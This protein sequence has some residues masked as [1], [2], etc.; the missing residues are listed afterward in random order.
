MSR[1]SLL[2]AILIGLA[3]VTVFPS[4]TAAPLAK[5]E[6]ALILMHGKWGRTPG[7]LARYF[8]REGYRVF[9]PEMPWSGRRLY[10]VNYRV[11]LE[12]V[13]REVERL[14]AA[15]AKKV[16]VGGESFGANGALAYQAVYGDADALLILAP[17]HMPGSWY[18]SGQ[19]RDDV[20][21]ASALSKE[22]KG[23]ER[24][25]FTDFNQE[26]QRNLSPTVD[27]FL[28][29]FRPNGLANMSASAKR[30][31]Q[32]VPVLVVNST[33]EVKNQGKGYIFDALPPHPRSVYIESALDHGSAAEG[34]RAD[35]Q[36]FLDS[37]AAD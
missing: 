21:R 24:F 1:R 14:R 6:I 20:D 33:N 26:R 31:K 25:S 36:R 23:G 32:P 8:E 30:I 22:K 5:G 2:V 15:G 13:H 34:A 10:D 28:S 12:E 27:A 11:G 37:I 29:F 3:L 16:I 7:P 19:T 9:S 17:G 18:R 35:A 4:V